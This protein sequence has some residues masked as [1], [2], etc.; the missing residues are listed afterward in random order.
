MGKEPY[1]LEGQL[2]LFDWI[3][4]HREY[5]SIDSIPEAEA[6]RIV[7]DEIGLTFAYNAR[8]EEWCAKKGKLELYLEYSNFDLE[9]N[10]DRFLGVGYD[11]GT[12]GGACPC[13]GIK[14]AVAWFKD[15][16]GKYYEG[17][18]K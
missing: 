9:D 6:A 13:S 12:G 1:T 18:Q 16:I 14:D 2:S 8:F 7:G 11:Y 5:P 3:P 4:E 15:K 10:L 17:K